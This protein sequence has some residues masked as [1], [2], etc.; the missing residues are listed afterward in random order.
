MIKRTAI[1]AFTLIETILYLALFNIIFAS[2][3]G[4]TISLTQSNKVAEYRNALD[5]DSMFVSE[6]L[7]DTFSKANTIDSINTTFQ[8]NQGKLRLNVEGTY[9][10]YFIDAS[11][12]KVTYGGAATYDLTSN[13]ASV[14]KF[15]LEP[16]VNKTGT[17]TGAKVTL[18]LTSPKYPNVVK[19]ISSYYDFR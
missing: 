1:Q 7:Y 12:L 14:T 4:F 15:Y 18:E 11:T 3:V 2:V 9:V 10:D 13:L 6:H 5:K 16:V 8:N 17:Q 19:T